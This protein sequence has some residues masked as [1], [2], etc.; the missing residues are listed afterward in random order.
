MD[1]M[2]PITKLTSI[3]KDISSG[4]Y[5]KRV[6]LKYNKNDELGELSNYFN[7]MADD[8][9]DK[10][11]T[12]EDE[13]QRKESFINNLYVRYEYVK[14]QNKNFYSNRFI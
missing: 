8:I 6:D 10:I 13:N 1:L 14:R 4:N 11:S 9:E 12:L 7:I 2:K 5:S 3:V